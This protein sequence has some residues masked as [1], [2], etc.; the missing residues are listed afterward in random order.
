MATTAERVTIGNLAVFVGRL[1]L[2]FHGGANLDQPYHHH[3]TAALRVSGYDE[4]ICSPPTPYDHTGR[5]LTPGDSAVL[6]CRRDHCPHAG[7]SRWHL[8]AALAYPSWDRTGLAILQ[9]A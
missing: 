2:D 9:D 7:E 8:V 6:V 3:S 4:V 5:A 1:S